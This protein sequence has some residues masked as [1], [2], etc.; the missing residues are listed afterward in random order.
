MTS[1]DDDPARD[2]EGGEPNAINTAGNQP[3]VSG[4]QSRGDAPAEAAR[5][6]AEKDRQRR[7]ARNEWLILLVVVVVGTFLLRQYVVQSYRIPSGSMEHTLHGCE[8]NCDDDRILVNK[9]AYKLHGIHHGDIVVFQATTPT[10]IAAAGGPNDVVKRVIGLPGDTVR[11]CDSQGRVVVDNKP[12]TENYVYQN[13]HRPFGP[14]TVPK[15]D[16]WVMGDHRADSSDSRYNGF[17]PISSVVGHAFMR[18]WPINRIGI[19]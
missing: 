15:G 5:A 2:V 9:L 19:L 6:K 8:Q 7:R 16:L 18:I 11:C 4:P 14:V 17:V 12:L 3:A 13:D 10:W 1:F